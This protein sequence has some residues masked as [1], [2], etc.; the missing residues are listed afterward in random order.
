M[1]VYQSKDIRNI[2]LMG[3]PATGKTTL[4]ECML[5]EGKVIERRGNIDSKNTTSDYRPIE[6]ER[7]NSIVASVLFSEYLDTKINIIDAPGFDDFIGEVITAMNFTEASLVLIHGNNGIEVGTELAWRNA[8]RNNQP[9]VLVVN[10]LDHEKA[11][12]DEIIRKARDIFSSKVIEVQ[13]PLNAGKDFN[14]VIDVLEMKMHKYSI[15]GGKVEILDIPASEMSKA[16]EYH[17]RLA[18]AAAE[19]DEALMETFFENGTL[20]Q[21]E[22][23]KGIQSGLM[24]REL[25]PVLC[26]SAKNNIG[27]SKLLEFIIKAVPSPIS[28]SMVDT[29]STKIECNSSKPF[30][31]YVFKTSFEEHLG[32]MS[33]IKVA[34]GEVTEAFDCENLNT[35]SKERISQLFAVAGKKRE[36]ME[37]VVAGDIFVTIKLKNTNTGNT[38]AAK[39]VNNQIQKVV[40]PEPKFRTAVKAVNTA[41]DEKLASVLQRMNASDPTLIF[42]YSK[43]L[44]QMLIHGQGELH[45][46]IAKW[47]LD[48]EFKIPTEFLVPKIPYRETITSISQ[49]TY[50]HKKQSGGAGQFG[51]VS[52]I[53]EPFEEGKPDP[54][55]FKLKQTI[56]QSSV[57]TLQIS[58]GDS[59]QGVNIR[60]KEEINLSWGGK[61][62]Y[63]NAIVGGVIDARFLPAI[64][65]GIMEKIEEGPLTGS[66]ARDIRVTVFDGKM[67]PVDSNEISFKLA[68]RTAFSYAFKHA[69]PKLL[70]PIYKIEVYLPEERMGDIMTDLQG[71]RAVILG[72]E[73]EGVYQKIIAKVPLAEMNKYS[74]AL[75]SLSNGRATYNMKFE[76]YAQVPPDIQEKL[77]K[78]YEESKKDED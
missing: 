41:D 77:L 28:S 72:M 61:L 69:N 49:A 24:K 15:S 65:K 78:E 54:S 66:Y 51:Q 56:Y 16:E 43:E 68:G 1:K 60:G 40:F 52:M 34:S 58:K 39:G 73:R 55:I 30:S 35:G 36:K 18:E 26:T 12:F 37:K 8:Y 70:E 46:N 57:T 25:F 2:T 17:N 27:V 10:H 33:F 31:G 48:N 19:N 47:H 42:E 3:G 20:S 44:K 11:E 23:I 53:L 5:F 74:T 38:L 13:Y 67:H 64:L 62:V 50:Q 29:S 22:I 59:E 7:L 76:E 14:T 9:V 32:E 4:A 6:H 71:R 75:S 63:Y 45:I 21:D